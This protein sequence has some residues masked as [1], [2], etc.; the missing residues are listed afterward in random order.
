MLRPLGG[1]PNAAPRLRFDLAAVETMAGNR[2]EA[3]DL[4]KGDMQSDKLQDAL[5]GFAA[6]SPTP[7]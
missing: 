2:Q 3:A 7:Q 6:L 4:L 1:V 5:D